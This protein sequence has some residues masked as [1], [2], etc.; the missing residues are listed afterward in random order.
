MASSCTSDLNSL[1]RH[2]PVSIAEE[3]EENKGMK[4]FIWRY[5]MALTHV[6]LILWSDPGIVHNQLHTYFNARVLTCPA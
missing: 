3:L 4:G 6:D 1:C 2:V 5:N